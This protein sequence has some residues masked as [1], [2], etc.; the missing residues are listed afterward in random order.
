MRSG[1]TSSWRLGALIALAAG[2][3]SSSPEASG[4]TDGG[5]KPAD[6]AADRRTVTDATR[7]GHDASDA[8]TGVSD[9]SRMSDGM[10]TGM[11]TGAMRDAGMGS[12]T[13]GDSGKRPESGT[14]QWTISGGTNNL[15]G[16]L[17]LNDNGACL[18]AACANFT[19]TPSPLGGNEVAF[20]GWTVSGGSNYSISLVPPLS[21]DCGGGT[22]GGGDVCWNGAGQANQSCTILQTAGGPVDANVASASGPQITCTTNTFLFG[23]TVLNLAPGNTITVQD[24]AANQVAIMGTGAATANFTLP[25][26]VLSG[27]GPFPVGGYTLTFAG[28]ST[29]GTTQSIGPGAADAGFQI[30]GA[31]PQVCTITAPA[32]PYIENA[33]VTPANGPVITCE[34]S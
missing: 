34:S 21:A 11:D 27:S 17:S 29:G 23:G 31:V 14:N 12:D 2:C 26:A 16:A 7:A 4:G 15:L 9:G 6:G 19:L 30:A 25:T 32:L 18:G 28:T 10:G 1:M 3:G 24:T 22:T 8:S 33:N 13:G 20:T 5:S